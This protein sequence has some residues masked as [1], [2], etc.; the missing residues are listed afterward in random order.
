MSDRRRM[1]PAW[2]PERK[3]TL[4]DRLCER[5]AIHGESLRAACSDPWMPSHGTILGWIA[6][7]P[8]KARQYRRALEEKANIRSDRIDGY[9]RKLLAGE[10]SPEAARVAI[11][12]EQWQASK[13]CPRRYGRQNGFAAKYAHARE[14]RPLTEAQTDAQI[15]HL[16]A[17]LGRNRGVFRPVRAG[18]RGRI[19]G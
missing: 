19:M 6:A 9:V 13:E 14:D 10:M 18:A 4:I 11:L 3:A 7:N 8:E 15:H 5:I 16:M 17:S 12:A 1:S 2:T